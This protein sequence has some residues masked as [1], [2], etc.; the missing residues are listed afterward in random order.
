MGLSTS[1]DCW[2]GAYST[3]HEWRQVLARAAGFPELME[4]AGF[5]SP[6]LPWAPYESDALV[7]LLNHADTHGSIYARDAARLAD[8]LDELLPVMPDEWR[9]RTA[10]FSVGL[11]AAAAAHQ[12]VEFS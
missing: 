2:D 10:Q 7:V 4:M 6:G 9:Q 1:H 12:D 11:R 5:T 8:R 3:F